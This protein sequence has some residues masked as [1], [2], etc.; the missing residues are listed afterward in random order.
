MAQQ[1]AVLRLLLVED[2]TE[3]AEHLIS[4]L[5]NGG[6]AVR[7]QRP[8]DESDLIR[9]LES[10]S[11][12]LVLAA[13][14]ANYLPLATVVQRVTATGKD[15]PIVASTAV[16]DEK[17]VMDALA[18][19]TRD[20]ALRT[21]PEHVQ[22]V[23]RNE[24]AALLARRALRHLEASLRET[25]RRCDAL[26]ASSRDPIAYVHEGMHIRANDAYLEMFGFED[27]DEIEGLSVLDLIDAKHADLFKQVLKKISKGE[28]PPRQL[29]LQ[30]QRADGSTF[31]A[32]MEFTS[33]TYEGESCLQ[34]VFRQQTVDADMVKELD[35]L[36]QRDSLTGLFNR[37]YFM[38]ELE[39]AVVKAADGKGQQAFLLVEPDHYENMV[40]EIGLASA[41]DLIKGFAERLQGA[42]D[43]DTLAARLSDHGFA[44][45]C[46][47]HD[48][49]ASL[50]QAERIREA[51]HGHILDLGERSV[52]PSVSIGGV[53]VGE[54][55]ASVSQV[56]SKS[57]QCLASCVGMGGNRVEIFDPA[58]RD[59]AEEER[60]QAWVVRI[61]EALAGDQF[62]LHYQPIISLTGAE[63]ENYDVYLRMKGPGGEVIP[64]LTYLAIAEEHGL[65]DDIDRWV[66]K[67]AVAVIGERM[68][69]GKHTNLF[70]KVTPASLVEG[71]LEGFIAEQLAAHAVPGDRLVLQIPESKVF[72]HLKAVQ[73]FQAAVAALGCR[74]ALEQF[75]TGLNSFQMLSHFDPA[76]LKIDRGFITEMGKNAEMQQQVR[77][78]VSKAHA[79]GKQTVAEFVSDAATMSVLFSMGMDFVEGNFLAAP[80]P[81]MNYDFG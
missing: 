27:F 13:A 34:I 32:V 58:A 81:T 80:G 9:L 14:N 30:A 25:E 46:L 67:R 7:P 24:F 62:T 71:G 28:T 75:G 19:G 45:L 17:T 40:G 52:N 78:I 26:I 50:A 48:H 68:K 77:D 16:L 18:A 10:Q 49:K 72:T 38:T 66:I 3:D 79:A 12:D 21:R 53:Q 2:Q 55:I 74:V 20:I 70:V 60:I 65:L 39:A 37:Q 69:A 29:D 15:I 33:A 54:R 51:F 63:E 35:T 61:R 1:D 42:L 22:A 57:S 73:A 5:R 8:E 4:L 59:R 6:I 44:V 36:R 64:P 31:D 76:I 41:D 23:V 47:G 11:I 43:A 56:M